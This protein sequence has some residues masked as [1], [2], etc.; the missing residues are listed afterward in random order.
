MYLLVKKK[1]DYICLRKMWD[2]KKI[3]LKT[4]VE[5]LKIIKKIKTKSIYTFIGCYIET[6]LDINVNWNVIDVPKM[7]KF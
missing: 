6:S 7:G 1:R 2:H 5:L 3:F 4:V